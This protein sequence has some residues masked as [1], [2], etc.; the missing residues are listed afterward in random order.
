MNS[1][2]VSRTNYC[3]WRHCPS[4]SIESIPSVSD[5]QFSQTRLSDPFEQDHLLIQGHPR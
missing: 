5:L 2:Y 1:K 3:G 4:I